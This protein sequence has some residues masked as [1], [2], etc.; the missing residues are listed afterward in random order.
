MK[1]AQFKIQADSVTQPGA[2]TDIGP[3][4]PALATAAALRGTLTVT[5]TGTCSA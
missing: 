5:V 4:P 2:Q 1:R 3:G